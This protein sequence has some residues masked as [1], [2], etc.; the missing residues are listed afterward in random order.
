LQRLALIGRRGR[1]SLRG[2]LG[3]QRCCGEPE[4]AQ[5]EQKREPPT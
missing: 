2:W 4:P 1:A 5:R 3:V